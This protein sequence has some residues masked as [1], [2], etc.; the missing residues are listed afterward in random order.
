[1]AI[2]Y[3]D[4][5]LDDAVWTVL[6]QSD[7]IA[8]RA[9]FS[10]AQHA[11]A[12]ALLEPDSKQRDPFAA[13]CWLN[14]AVL[15]NDA[16][17]MAALGSLYESGDGLPQDIECAIRFYRQAAD[18]GDMVGQEN[19]AAIH[20]TPGHR[21]DPAAA[22]WWLDLAAKQGSSHARFL[23]G[24]MFQRGIGMM[25][26]PV[27]AANWYLA[28][29]EAGHPRAQLE[30]G[31]AY[32]DGLGVERNAAEAI[33]WLERAVEGGISEAPSLIE[34]ARLSISS[35]GEAVT[36]PA[37]ITNDEPPRGIVMPFRGPAQRDAMTGVPE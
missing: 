24:V 26:D 18:A 27:A 7:E 11:L 23:F 4:N 3:D 30:L 34:C 14:L 13:A 12:T 31:R 29:A 37:D 2:D 16:R 10:S 5:A 15:Q 6:A 25:R 19:L 32:L 9:G 20:L 21:F 17:A 8:A 33:S 35:A 1:M 28:A 36:L 22:A